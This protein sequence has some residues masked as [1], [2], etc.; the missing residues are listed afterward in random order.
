MNERELFEILEEVAEKDLVDGHDIYD[1]PCTV[2]VRA[3]KQ[4][5]EDISY[6]KRMIKHPTIQKSK[7]ARLLLGLSYHLGV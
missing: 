6:L 1:H 3:I 2:A 4:C 5:F 7:R